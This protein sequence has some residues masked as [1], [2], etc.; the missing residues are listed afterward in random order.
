M[1]LEFDLDND[2][3]FYPKGILLTGKCCVFIVTLFKYD[4]LNDMR[5]DAITVWVSI[6]G[7]KNG[8]SCS[9][10]FGKDHDF[11]SNTKLDHF[12]V[13]FYLKLF[14]NEM[15]QFQSIWGKDHH[16]N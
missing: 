13:L 2:T 11:Q 14:N 15:F 7:T 5:I 3:F 6:L 12:L 8:C 4:L 9:L 10:I 16:F 1:E